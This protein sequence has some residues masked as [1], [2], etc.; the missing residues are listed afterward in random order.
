[1]KLKPKQYKLC[2]DKDYLL[3]YGLIAQQVQAEEELSEF[4]I[5]DEEYIANI[6]CN[7]I[8]NNK[9]IASSKNING[10]ININDELKL[11]LDN[12]MEDKEFIIEKTTYHNRYKKRYI[13]VIN[14]IDDY[15]FEIDNE[16]KVNNNN[17]FFL[18]KKREVY[19]ISPRFSRFLSFPDF[20]TGKREKKSLKFSLRRQGLPRNV[21]P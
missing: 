15:S 19:P 11:I 9:I 5:N 7:G 8:Y 13:K 12:K 3:K 1:M 16:I 4:V 6:Y 2:D 14:I 18:W 21:Q 20:E 10:L 17:I